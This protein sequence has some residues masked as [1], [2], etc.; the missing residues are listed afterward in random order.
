MHSHEHEHKYFSDIHADMASQFF[1]MPHR[2]PD[3]E[4][5]TG[6]RNKLETSTEDYG[7]IMTLAESLSFQLR[8]REA[9]ELYDR[10]L[11]IRPRSLDALQARAG[12]HF[13]TLQFGKSLDDYVACDRI[14]PDDREIIYRLGIVEYAV[15][16]NVEAE[17]H[18]ARCFDMY[19]DDPEMLVASAFWLALA[20]SRTKS[21]AGLWKT[22]DFSLST[23]HHAGYNDGLRVL[24]GIDSA[25]ETYEK[26]RE[27][28]D[29]LQASIALYA[30][31]IHYRN[32]GDKKREGEIYS[33]LMT[34]D[35]YWAGITYVAAFAE[36]M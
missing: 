8:Y 26:W 28:E 1:G 25:E 3:T 10:A 23:P 29:K 6:L 32:E 31:V 17:S 35:E 9:I 12:R 13:K 7:I 18:F 19:T 24:A 11:K 20:E 33:E 15:G 27:H 34:T 16:I 5:I 30:L 14:S 4:E 2:V 36:R 21:G 22:Y